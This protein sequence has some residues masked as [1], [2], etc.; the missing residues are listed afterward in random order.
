MSRMDENIDDGGLTEQF[1]RLGFVFQR[2][3]FP[4]QPNPMLST[5]DR[6]YRDCV[7]RLLGLNTAR[8]NQIVS[9][10]LDEWNPPVGMGNE[11]ANNYYICEFIR[12]LSVAIEEESELISAAFASAEVC[13]LENERRGLNARSRPINSGIGLE[14][15]ISFTSTVIGPGSPMLSQ[16]AEFGDS[17]DINS[18]LSSMGELGTTNPIT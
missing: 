11:T 17:F 15:A 12:R 5:I 16:R 6:E 2:F 1:E 3:N 10:S 14:R 7:V 4:T 8:L 13:P 18:P 9:E